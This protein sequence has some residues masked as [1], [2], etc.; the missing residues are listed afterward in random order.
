VNWPVA[1]RLAALL[2]ERHSATIG[3]RSLDVLHVA[4]ARSLRAGEFVTFDAR[5]RTLALALGLKVGP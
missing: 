4:V 5:Q 2:S 1:L 3:T